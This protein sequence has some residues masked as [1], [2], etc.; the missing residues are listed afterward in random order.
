MSGFSLILDGAVRKYHDGREVCTK[1]ARGNEEY[2]RRRKAMAD[3]QGWICCLCKDRSRRMT[4]SDVTF[5]H[6]KGRGMNGAHRDDRIV[7]DEGKPMNGAAHSWC[8]VEK[9]SKRL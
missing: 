5:E 8:N 1:T 7:D 9:G 2:W 6:S 4:P 3:R